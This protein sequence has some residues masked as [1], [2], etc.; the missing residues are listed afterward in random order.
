MRLDQLRTTLLRDSLET[1]V[2]ALHRRHAAEIPEDFIDDYVGLDWL[3]WRGG[4][5]RLTTTGENVCQ[6]LRT[7][8]RDHS[9]KTPHAVT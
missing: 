1:V 5:L 8:A 9:A 3:E 6:Q 7:Q 4:T 2:D